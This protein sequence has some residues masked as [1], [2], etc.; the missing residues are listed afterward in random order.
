MRNE[1]CWFNNDNSILSASE[2]EMAPKYHLMKKMS[3]SMKFKNRDFIRRG[4]CSE[5]TVTLHVMSTARCII[6][7][8]VLVCSLAIATM[9]CKTR[10]IVSG[11]IM[12]AKCTGSFIKAFIEVDFSFDHTEVKVVGLYIISD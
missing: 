6:R 1:P 8:T 7:C 12:K 4:K 3:S 11:K 2:R 9:R 5:T 10:L